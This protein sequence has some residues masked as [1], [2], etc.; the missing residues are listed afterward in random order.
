MVIQQYGFVYVNKSFQNLCVLGIKDFENVISNDLE[1]PYFF[2]L[3]P[4]MGA[5]RGP[6]KQN[7]TVVFPKVG[8][9]DRVVS[10]NV[11]S[12]YKNF[13]LRMC[14]LLFAWGGGGGGGQV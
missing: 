11:A 14:L 7:L 4:T 3:A 6:P 10:L 1:T 13:K 2:R 9:Y 8:N 5:P 12:L